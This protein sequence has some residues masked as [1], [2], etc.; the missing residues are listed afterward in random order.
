MNNAPYEIIAAPF[1]VWL[2]DVG[3]SYP[4]VG[5]VPSGSWLKLGAS[6]DVNINE[7]GVSVSHPQNVE[8]LRTL[9]S[10]LPVKAFRTEEDL[11]ISFMLLDLRLEM[12]R[13]VL[14]GNSLN[15]VDAVAGVPGY[16]SLPFYR[17][18]D[19]TQQAL[20]IR[21]LSAYGDGMYADFRVPKVVHIG[22]P[23]V[24]SK[25]GE[26]SGLAFELHAIRDDSYAGGV[27]GE[28]VMQDAAA[29]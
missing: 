24:I 11:I 12:Y 26:P 27:A 3:T 22:E 20:L 23:E 7:D 28:L 1:T 9:G 25:K 10:T 2:A 29:L 16:K 13:H 19:V 4:A 8:K 5:A 21:G 15:D 17:G 18:P 6:G 14:N